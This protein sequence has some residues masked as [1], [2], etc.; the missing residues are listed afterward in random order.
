MKKL[1]LFA[2][3]ADGITVPELLAEICE[4]TGL[5]GNQLGKIICRADKT[6]INAMPDDAEKIL[7][8]FR[9][10]RQWRFKYDEPREERRK[11]KFDRGETPESPAAGKTVPKKREAHQETQVMEKKG[12]KKREKR[13]SEKKERPPRKPLREEF[14]KWIADSEEF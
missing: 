7:K 9:N 4:R 3:R 5:R 11:K 6:F 12:K 13:D 10:D 2:G 8:A 1:L 14:M